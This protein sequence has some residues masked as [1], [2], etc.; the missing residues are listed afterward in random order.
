MQFVW[1]IVELVI[2]STWNAITYFS[3]WT[4][5]A[6]AIMNVWLTDNSAPIDFFSQSTLVSRLFSTT[7]DDGKFTE[8]RC[9]SHPPLHFPVSGRFDRFFYDFFVCIFIRQQL[10]IVVILVALFSAESFDHYSLIMRSLPSFKRIR[11]F[12][13][14][15]HIFVV[16]FEID[17]CL[18]RWNKLQGLLTLN[19]SIKDDY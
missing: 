9:V 5:K 6:K 3:N 17:H 18:Q 7:S 12:C 15:N 8:Y 16:I 13:F 4:K 10:I 1:F 2:F 11:H 19:T 14:T